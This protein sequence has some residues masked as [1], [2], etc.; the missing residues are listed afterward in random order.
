MTCERYSIRIMDAALGALSASEH[1]EL[2][3]HIDACDACRAAYRR[4]G[5]VVALVDRGVGSLVEGTPSPA[6]A[7]RLRA[8][9][10]EE[11]API[12]S[13][14][15]LRV[16]AAAGA[17]ALAA[18]LFLAAIYAVGWS[19]P[20]PAI[21]WKAQ[22]PKPP[23]IAIGRA[24]EH[25]GSVR[26]ISPR[27]ARAP[28]AR[29]NGATAVLVE[30]NQAAAVERFARAIGGN[31]ESARQLLSAERKFTE[32]L[33]IQTLDVAPIRLAGENSAKGSADSGGF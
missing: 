11:A 27:S 33:E 6:F 8:R 2:I 25:A 5:E 23:A 12:Y 15:G 24:V 26:A 31:E 18:A 3:A 29:A 21:A 1:A 30:P 20:A 17:F 19:R 16:A 22:A 32:P 7:V 4:A 13:V 10:A 14:W 9:L 28:L